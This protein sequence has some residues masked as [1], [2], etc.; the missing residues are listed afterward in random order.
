[1]ALNP[2][3]PHEQPSPVT[4]EAEAAITAFRFV[5]RG[6]GGKQVT[7]CSVSGEAAYGV[8]LHQADAG[9]AVAVQ[10][11][12]QGCAVPVESGAAIA[13]LHDNIQTDASGRAIAAIAT[14]II[15][16]VNNAT[17]AGAGELVQISL[18]GAQRVEP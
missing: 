4:R 12:V 10:P 15:L 9:E 8:A 5:K 13:A 17:A 14:K 7:P 3:I 11:L 6:T 16:G 2:N 1:M 18:D